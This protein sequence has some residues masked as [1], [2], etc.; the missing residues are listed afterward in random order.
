MQE[1]L[2]R[3]RVQI[4]RASDLC[5]G[6]RGCNWNAQASTQ[7]A[8]G[9]KTEDMRV[10]AHTERERE[11]ERR[12]AHLRRQATANCNAAITAKEREWKYE[13]SSN[14]Y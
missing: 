11:R 3:D 5:G 8:S 12:D 6:P 14:P 13:D 1:V 10:E 7:Q 2:S 4:L 9:L